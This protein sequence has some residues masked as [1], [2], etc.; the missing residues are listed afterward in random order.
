M[1]FNFIAKSPSA[2]EGMRGENLLLCKYKRPRGYSVKLILYAKE[3][4]KIEDV[5]KVKDIVNIPP[6]S[7][8]RKYQHDFS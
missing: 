8:T 1:I 2:R 4:S 6:A 7:C 3:D 5:A